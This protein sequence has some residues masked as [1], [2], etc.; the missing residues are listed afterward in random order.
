MDDPFSRW[1]RDAAHNVQLRF[2]AVLDDLDTKTGVSLRTLRM[3]DEIS[4]DLSQRAAALLDRGDTC[5]LVETDALLSDVA[6]VKVSVADAL[7]S[8]TDAAVLHLDR[9]LRLVDALLSEQLRFTAANEVL[10]PAAPAAAPLRRRSSAGAKGSAGGPE[11]SAQRAATA[12][13]SARALLDARAIA[14]AQSVARVVARGTTVGRGADAGPIDAHEP[15]YCSC[16]QV[17]A[18]PLR[19]WRMRDT[20]YSP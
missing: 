3:L 11:T 16:N 19:V 4:S 12:A 15:T 13:S 6:A 9:R 1:P 7:Y 17:S 20:C 14:R 5:E 10:P 18:S 8:A 2:Q